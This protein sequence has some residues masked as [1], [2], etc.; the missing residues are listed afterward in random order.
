M[1]REHE[2]RGTEARGQ[3]AGVTGSPDQGGHGR[4]EYLCSARPDL[5]VCSTP[6]A[7]PPHPQSS[8]SATQGPPGRPKHAWNPSLCCLHPCPWG[9]ISPMVRR[10]RPTI[11]NSGS[12]WRR[13]PESGFSPKA[14]AWRALGLALWVTPWA[15]QEELAHA[16]PD[17]Q[18]VKPGPAD[19][20]S[21]VFS[22]SCPA[23]QLPSPPWAPA[24]LAF[25]L[26]PGHLLSSP[27]SRKAPFHALVGLQSPAR[28]Q[29]AALP[30]LSGQVVPP[31]KAEG[32]GDRAV[33]AQQLSMEG[34]GFLPPCCTFLAPRCG[35]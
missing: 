26:G 6:A 10:T 25:S 29:A 13:D 24:T 1:A 27:L 35:P 16:L 14:S 21:P 18:A 32:L 28:V 30:A 22:P 31:L 23:A 15:P 8:H 33:R 9:R 11:T 3:L 20:T 2:E 5:P 7:R 17:T 12:P 19:L 34:Q 4:G